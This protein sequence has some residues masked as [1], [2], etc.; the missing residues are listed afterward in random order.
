MLDYLKLRKQLGKK[1]CGMRV[2]PRVHP[3]QRQIKWWGDLMKILYER[4]DQS[5]WE[6]ERKRT[7]RRPRNK[8]TA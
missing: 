8:R 4:A 5:F 7:K 2:L 1:D 6:L 3:E